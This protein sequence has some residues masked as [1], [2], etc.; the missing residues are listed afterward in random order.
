VVAAHR[1]LAVAIGI[2]ADEVFGEPPLTPHPVA[3]FGSVMA[4]VENRLYADSRREGIAHAFAGVALGAGAGAALGSTAVA[5]YVAVAGRALREAAAAVGAALSSGDLGEARRLLPSLV[6]RN[7]DDLDAGE[8][9]RAVVE[10]LAENTVDAVVAPCLW[11]L[12]AG[13]PGA[14]AY[15]AI[16]TLDAMVGH[17]SA[18]YG[19]YGWAS[20]RLD[21][22][23][24]WV[25][26]RV[27]AALVMLVR[28]GRAGDVWRAVCDDAP[29]HPS[30][31]AGVAEAA[32]AGAL[33]LQLGGTNRYGP[34]TEVRPWLGRGAPPHAGDIARSA[35]L[36]RDVTAAL[37]M[38]LG[39]GG[40]VAHRR[41][42]PRGRR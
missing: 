24:N 18:R 15:R 33:G 38:L 4:A 9:S 11:A 36:S 25:P 27:T 34:R 32:W 19:R 1:G 40:A 20:A 42:A 8:I 22:A 6:G 14:L 28:P 7:P 39:A 21:D 26:A 35:A 5:V 23:A 41:A 29:A 12:A 13:A 31:N 2:V 10:S 17:R 37:A 3:A 30:P 16:N